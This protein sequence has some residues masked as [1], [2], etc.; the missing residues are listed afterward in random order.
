MDEPTRAALREIA[1]EWDKAEKVMKEAERLNGAVI[2]PSVN[3]LRYAGRRLVD[4]LNVADD[5]ET[6]PTKK[7][8]F[9]G[10]IKDCLFRIHC[11]QHD[12]VDSSVLFVQRAIE[13]YESEFGRVILATHFPALTDLRGSLVEV[14]EIIIASREHRGRRVSDYD[15]IAQAHLPELVRVYRTLSTNRA[16]LEALVKDRTQQDDRET[17]RFRW[18]IVAVIFGGLIIALIGALA[19][20]AFVHVFS[21]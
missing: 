3:E 2:D 11:A 6:D 18:N 21:N 5:A 13:T 1:H 15:K 14:D 9:D 8:D 7:K 17:Q 12:A 19:G 10:Y 20:A 4:A 16:T